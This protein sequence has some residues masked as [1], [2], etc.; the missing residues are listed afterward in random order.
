MAGAVVVLV[1]TAM[2]HDCYRDDG[3]SHGSTIVQWIR[4]IAGSMLK[5]RLEIW[6][7]CLFVRN[8]LAS[9]SIAR[10]KCYR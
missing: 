2:I 6:M 8:T 7:R 3:F 10:G 9:H 1:E 5:V 4:T